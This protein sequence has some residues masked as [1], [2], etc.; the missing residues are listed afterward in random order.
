MLLFAG[1]RIRGSSVAPLICEVS[2]SHSSPSTSAT[3][4]ASIRYRSSIS[5][6]RQ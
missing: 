6:V 5:S 3:V 2:A 1:I 4:S